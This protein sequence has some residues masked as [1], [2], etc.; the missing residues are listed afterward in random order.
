MKSNVTGAAGV[1]K[2]VGAGVVVAALGGLT[3]VGVLDLAG[4]LG[5]ALGGARHAIAAPGFQPAVAA[6]VG[7][8]DLEKLIAGLEEIRVKEQEFQRRGEERQKQLQS[9]VDERKK[10]EDEVNLLPPSDPARREKVVKMLELDAV[11]KARYEGLQNV[12][13]LEKGQLFRDSYMK[14]QEGVRDLAE[15]EGLDVVFFDD[16]GLLLPEIASFEELNV[17]VQNKK[18]LYAGPGVDFTERLIKKMNAEYRAGG[19]TAPTTTS[20]TPSPMGAGDGAKR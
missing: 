1:M 9:A 17:R 10:I 12:I 20:P 19:G 15:K 7:V 3:A 5:S 11:T 4:G 8:V 18:I 14:I 2:L 6:K 13:N 16:R